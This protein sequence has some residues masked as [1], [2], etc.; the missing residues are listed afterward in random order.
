MRRR[1]ARVA[2]SISS[3]SLLVVL[4]EY[5]ARPSRVWR[6]LCGS[7]PT[8]MTETGSS[9]C[10]SATVRVLLM[11]LAIKTTGPRPP[12]GTAPAEPD[13]APADNTVPGRSGPMAPATPAT[14]SPPRRRKSR[15]VSGRRRDG[16]TGTS[17]TSGRQEQIRSI[18]DEEARRQPPRRPDRSPETASGD[19]HLADDVEQRTRRQRKEEHKRGQ[20]SNAIAHQRPEKRRSSADEPGQPQKRPRR[21][22]SRRSQRRGDGKSFG[23]VESGHQND[24]KPDRPRRGALPDRQTFREVVKTQARGNHQRQLRRG[25][26]TGRPP[27]GRRVEHDQSHQTDDQAGH[28][29]R[30][31]QPKRSPVTQL[32]AFLHR[33]LDGLEGFREDI[34]DDKQEHAERE[35]RQEALRTCRLLP[36]ARRRQPQVNCKPG[37]RAEDGGLPYCHEPDPPA[38]NAHP[39]PRSKTTTQYE[40]RCARGTNPRNRPPVLPSARLQT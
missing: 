18:R 9:R 39:A 15:R 34:P 7:R 35:R 8:L 21:A 20:R 23:D 10:P 22:L 4:H 27:H 17:D 36:E 37:D 13:G 3:I 30:D 11:L 31:E 33:R 12:S 25:P 1:T 38:G 40:S 6:N 2:R 29:H 28:K 16:R 32:R 24:R 26:R 14:A 5:T 19:E